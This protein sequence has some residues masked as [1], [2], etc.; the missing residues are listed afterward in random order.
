ME[1]QEIVYQDEFISVRKGLFEYDG[2]SLLDNDLRDKLH[3]YTN[4]KK[5][6]TRYWL[7]NSDGSILY[8]HDDSGE[9]CG[10]EFISS[11][12]EGI[13]RL[14]FSD[15][16]WYFMT[17]FGH[18]LKSY[19]FK[20]AS[21][22]QD[23]VA[24]VSV[25]G[26]GDCFI[27]RDGC[28]FLKNK[29]NKIIPIPAECRGGFLIDDNHIAL[30][31][32]GDQYFKMYDGDMNPIM[33]CHANYT[34]QIDFFEAFEPGLNDWSVFLL[35]C[36]SQLG[37]E[38]R[39]DQEKYRLKK[40]IF[41]LTDNK[42]CFSAI[43]AWEDKK[44]SMEVDKG[45]CAFLYTAIGCECIRITSN[46]D[47]WCDNY[48]SELRSHDITHSHYIEETLCFE[49]GSVVGFPRDSEVCPQ[50]DI[51]V[52]IV[53]ERVDLCYVS[54]GKK[55]KYGCI[56]YSGEIVI[57]MEY[58]LIVNNNGL[59]E[60][61]YDDIVCTFNVHGRLLYKDKTL[62]IGIDL[63]KEVNGVLLVKKITSSQQ[64]TKVLVGIIDAE[65][66]EVIIP[67][68]YDSID[69]KS[70][71]SI[72]FSKDGMFGLFDADFIETIP[73]VYKVLEYCTDD[74]FI[75]SVVEHKRIRIEGLQ[76][77]HEY[78][79]TNYG[80]IDRFQ[81]FLVEPVYTKIE[82]KDGRLHFYYKD[83]YNVSFV[84]DLSLNT[85][86]YLSEDKPFVLKGLWNL[87]GEFCGN[88]C[89]FV[90]KDGKF[91]I[92]DI[93]SEIISR[94]KYDEIETIGIS[95]IYIGVRADCKFFINTAEHIEKCLGF[96][97]YWM[98]EGAK[99][100]NLICV[101]SAYGI[102]LINK[103]GDV[104]LDCVYS[105]VEIYEKCIKLIGKDSCCGI[106]DFDGNVVIPC[107]Y[108]DIAITSNFVRLQQSTDG[109]YGIA[110]FAGKV[111]LPCEY[112]EIRA[113]AGTQLF[114][115]C[116]GLCLDER[117]GI[118]DFS[119]EILIPC[120]YSD[121][122]IYSARLLKYSASLLKM[123]KDDYY[124]IA[125]FYG[126]ILLP[127]EYSDI[128][129]YGD[130]GLLKIEKGD[131]YGIAD[132]YGHIL[133]PCEY[134]EIRIGEHSLSLR[135]GDLWGL[136]NLD[137]KIILPCEFETIKRFS[138]ENYSRYVV[139]KKEFMGLF[140]LYAGLLL[141]PE[142]G[143]LSI[144]PTGTNCLKALRM[145]SAGNCYYGLLSLDGELYRS[146]DL[147]FIGQF[148][149][150]EAIV[151]YGGEARLE[152]DSVGEIKEGR[153]LRGGKFGVVDV[154]GNFVIEPKYDF[155][156]ENSEGYRIV[157]V[158]GDS[159]YLFGLV[160]ANGEVL[161]CKCQYIRAVVAG[162]IVYAIG[163]DWVANG[164]YG[165]RLVVP[166]GTDC[167]LDGAKWGIMDVSSKEIVSPFADFMQ[168]ISEGRVAYR[169]GDKYG[170]LN[171][172]TLEKKM[173]DYEFLGS[174]HGGI[175][176][177]AESGCYGYVNDRL[178][179]VVPCIYDEAYF[180]DGKH[181]VVEKG[182]PY[183]VDSHF[184]VKVIGYHDSLD[185]EYDYHDSSDYG[186]DTW[187]AMTDGQYG[188]YPGTGV[189]YDFLGY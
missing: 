70:A 51:G 45:S 2:K 124:G 179:A 117:Y 100:D 137:G 21:D 8:F 41:R 135:V 77:W 149:D 74:M 92:L 177:A 84:T 115:I 43:D 87:Y 164:R 153:L 36:C 98:P 96:S 40:C 60:A 131:Y 169:I 73:C 58:D 133:L 37:L 144:R 183:I 130:T 81:N 59:L 157:A 114:K 175:C 57:P 128:R 90:D 25:D 68:E 33:M 39:F 184:N 79:E 158:K 138:R 102:G 113:F 94:N 120:E 170:V 162:L 108:M 91:G 185:E 71:T 30:L 5:V 86:V 82:L 44:S 105:E 56:S 126:H 121:I 111:L 148:R 6:L 4:T 140:D 173:T 64:K 132:F 9:K 32:A 151:N 67:I 16:E 154:K 83:R 143:Y 34:F 63:C 163:G 69:F 174:Y 88:T 35:N 14:K 172:E 150:G 134:S 13:V 7:Y 159:S 46:V 12:K 26:G 15:G 125:D 152:S 123:E 188:D 50:D 3:L 176:D 20:T 93:D 97:Q 106:A 110:N 139:K 48:D 104:V 54:G 166:E 22:F 189:D 186:R 122:R 29:K 167:Y 101:E 116:K 109:S 187:N 49:N 27:S 112:S 53:A 171:L 65:N 141:S 129:V 89:R 66:F 80:V 165:E 75:C 52:I 119:G 145:D 42:I 19:P 161:A 155:V 160:G 180:E 85:I 168:P 103:V 99:S 95:G 24:V 62:P 11:P 23:G 55:F 1:E 182:F 47:Y 142:D 61:S 31:N 146:A 181:F 28:L 72:V 78:E 18:L 107:E 10:Y 76:K 136:A 178:E 147:S 38:N 127:C 17:V 156:L 118:A